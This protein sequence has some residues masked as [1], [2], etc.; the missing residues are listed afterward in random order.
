MHTR[1]E[2]QRTRMQQEGYQCMGVFPIV[3]VH[4]DN[5]LY[6][7]NAPVAIQTQNVLR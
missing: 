5:A 6:E 1:K 7:G 4:A 2:H 3:F